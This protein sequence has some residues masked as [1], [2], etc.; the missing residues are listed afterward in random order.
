MVT[1]RKNARPT[2]K[3]RPRVPPLPRNPKVSLPTASLLDKLSLREY[4]REAVTK[5]RQYIANFKRSES[6]SAALVHM[7][8]GTG[9]TGV[10]AALA[11]C[12]PELGAVV[13]LAPRIALCDQLE[14]FIRERFFDHLEQKPAKIPK[15]V[16]R[17]EKVIEKSNLSLADKVIVST[18]QMLESMSRTG[19]RRR[20]RAKKALYDRLKAEVDLIVVDEGHYEPA[21]S[22]SK[23]VREFDTPRVLFTA[24][25]YRNDLKR[26]N[27]NFQYTLHFTL[28][29]A[30][31]KAVIRNVDV[32]QRTPTRN[33]REFIDDVLDFYDSN[34][35]NK[36]P[37]ARVIIRCDNR[38][39]IDQMAGVL[40]D[41]KRPFVAI[42]DRF[43]DDGGEPWER[44]SVPRRKEVDDDD[45]WYGPDG[46]V[47]WVHQF[48]LLE[49][50]DDHRFRLVAIF[51]PLTNDRQ[52]VQ[53]IGRVIRN[54]EIPKADTA[55]VLDHSRGHHQRA[56]NALFKYDDDLKRLIE[57]NP[58]RSVESALSKPLQRDFVDRVLEAHPERAYLDGK[59]R[60]R[61]SFKSF[62]PL[63]E[64]SLPL[65]A[66]VLQK[67][68]NFKLE[69]LASYVHRQLL[70]EDRVV[71]EY[72]VDK[73]T[74][75]LLYVSVSN[76]AFLESSY[77]LS[78]SPGIIIIS[79]LD[80]LVAFYDSGGMSPL[81]LQG[82]GKAARPEYLRKLFSARK[83]SKLVEVAAKN[84]QLGNRAI[85]TRSMSA[86]SLEETVPGLED[87]VQVLTR[88]TGYSAEA[89]PAWATRPQD[90]VRRRYIGFRHGRVVESTE[91]VSL[92]DYRAWLNDVEQIVTGNRH[93]L[94][95]FSRYAADVTG[96]SNDDA[97]PRNV[98]LDVYEVLESYK[99]AGN[100]DWGI[101][102]GLPMDLEDL[103][104]NVTQRIDSSGKSHFLFDVKANGRSCKVEIEWDR[105]RRRYVLFSRELDSM[106]IS[107]GSGS[108]VGYLNR[109]QS[110]RVIPKEENIIYVDGEFYE[111]IVPV[112]S[113]FD[114]KRYHVG[115]ILEDI[116]A[117]KD[118]KDE[119]G[120]Q[121][122]P[123]GSDWDPKSIFGFISR[124]IKGTNE[125]S[126]EFNAPDIAVC[127]DMGTEIADFIVA[128]KNHVV[129]IHAK[130][131]G[132]KAKYAAAYSAG[133]LTEVCGQATKN[134]RFL[135]MFNNLKPK[136]LPR[137]GN[138]WSAEPKTK[139]EVRSRIL[140]PS[141]YK[142][143]DEIW[144]RI[145]ERIRNPRTTREVW[146]VVGG[147]LSKSRLEQELKKATPEAVQ[148]VTLLQG[149]LAAIG[150]IDAKLRVF[151]YP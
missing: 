26:F 63:D 17:I 33:P 147:I 46:P 36:W 71:E 43:K 132:R 100:D 122:L 112:G 129:F 19:S 8:T 32:V 106:Y 142:D 103:C 128:G 51:E 86:A 117:L 25:P 134:I 73:T 15:E 74:R 22:W 16:I 110:F 31:N 107:E 144:E 58:N 99:T 54:P 44:R 20:Q 40:H 47:F 121:S 148:A 38:A 89:A 67:P 125:L 102:A 10:I 50:I 48:K 42:H 127:D 135:S 34:L 52:V 115:R 130:G 91:R 96:V 53:Q 101:K 45:P 143:A 37:D 93:K 140:K 119:K 41:K 61:F 18:I 145:Q 131:I 59:A 98:L 80:K 83:A 84:A 62:T 12:T 88:V 60:T 27:W 23:A 141:T 138:A 139:G 35:K 4:Q 95:T 28:S 87:H 69:R 6:N 92:I 105:K 72:P 78:G 150:S 77:F 113:Q 151:C 116:P 136:N 64:L 108:L 120:E 55:F 104:Q 7:A 29:E 56:W 49:G 39:S 118:L 65:S 137:W 123:N 68:K 146:V 82:V 109:E 14:I 111:L 70:E 126:R 21:L 79:E 114:R 13:V 1:S 124:G 90:T 11:R 149:T 85:R 2:G 57:E 76:V 9:K 30:T 94:G 97:I 81:G 3:K 5:T 66:N 24:T 133:K 75:V